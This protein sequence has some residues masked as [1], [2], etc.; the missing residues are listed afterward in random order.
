MVSKTDYLSN[1]F[2][3]KAGLVEA[4]LVPMFELRDLVLL[5]SLCRQTRKLF[6]PTSQHHI[7]YTKV[8][9]EK[10]QID[11]NDLEAV[12]VFKA[13]NDKASWIAILKVVADFN[14][15]LRLMPN[16]KSSYTRFDRE[17]RKKEYLSYTG[18]NYCSHME[19]PSYYHQKCPGET[20]GP[21]KHC[22]TL[23]TVCWMD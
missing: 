19:N 2:K 1:L 23:I 3:S 5:S 16:S 9:S 22:N 12:E 10:L 8:M 21:G 4:E 6:D 11:H 13:L 15:K 18:S 17:Y 14:T 7:N 20:F